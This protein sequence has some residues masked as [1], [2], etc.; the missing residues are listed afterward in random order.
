ME[1]GFL[2]PLNLL[3]A[4]AVAVPV[5]I[6]LLQRRREA[7]VDFPAVRF[8]LIAQRRSSRRLRLRRLLLLLLRCLAVIAFALL[9]ARPVLQAPGA[10][11][12]EGE[13][14]FT[15][16]ILDTSLSMSALS[17]DDRQRF[18]AARDLARALAARGGR[19][20]RFA[21]IEAAPPA[22]APE[23]ARWLDRD[24]FLG[25]LAAAAARPAVADPA[26]AFAEA[27]RLLGE[28]GG[29]QRRIVVVSDLARGG[30]DRFSLGDLR[31]ID[32]AIPVRVLRLAGDGARNRAGVVSL[33]ASGESRIAGEPR[34]VVAEVVNAGPERALPVELWIDGALAASRIE[35]VPPGTK[36]RLAFTVRPAA[37]GARR[38]EVRVPADR[39]PADDR[40]H[41]AL[42][43]APPVGALVVDGDPGTSLAQGETFFLQEALRHERLAATVPVRITVAGPEAPA[44]PVPAGTGGG[45]ARE[46]ARAGR[47]GR[48]APRGARRRRRRPARLLG[49]GLRRRGLAPRA[50]GAAP[51]AGRRDRDGGLGGGVADRRG[52]PGLAA[53][54]RLRPARGRDARDRL[55]HLAGTARAGRCRPRACSRASRTARRGSS[56]SRSGAAASCSRPRRPISR[57]TICR[58][59][60]PTCRS[61]SVSSSGSRGASSRPP[62]PSSSRASRSRSRAGRSLWGRGRPWSRRA[63]PASRR[64]SGPTGAGS[65]ALLLPAAAET[66]FYRWTRPGAEGLVAVN[67]PAAES[68]LSALTPEETAERMRPVRAELVDV[69]PGG[70][71]GDPSRLGERSLARP[72][73]AALLALLL[74][75]AL[76]AGPRA[77]LARVRPRRGSCPGGLT[78]SRAPPVRAAGA[79]AFPPAR[80]SARRGERPPPRRSPR[81]RRRGGGPAARRRGPSRR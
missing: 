2:S 66:G 19:G 81:R 38:L 65:R 58:R 59:G 32:A 78:G 80:G 40:R 27:Y 46:R 36:G 15:A 13:P 4:L 57:A 50:P 5:A 34:E 73:L 63:A 21:L 43:V 10:A 29:E 37:G 17:A 41:L 54:R 14:G 76:V 3:F 68:E 16:V 74:L 55:L 28:V 30:W 35:T 26:R 52:G 23:A 1:F 31:A 49:G 61:C 9:L 6:H 42:E 64:S 56:S 67:V 60:R 12:R 47:G 71:E 75:E 79:G 53:A 33:G 70:V 24:G 44:A 62:T 77:A 72:L 8:L 39:Y 69:K 20:E 45:R 11:F 25:A 51:G 22:G 7:T 48:P 18:E